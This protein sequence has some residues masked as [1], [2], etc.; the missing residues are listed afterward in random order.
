LIIWKKLIEDLLTNW[1]QWHFLFIIHQL[2]CRV[3]SKKNI[4]HI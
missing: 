1:N 3:D 4:I 2:Y